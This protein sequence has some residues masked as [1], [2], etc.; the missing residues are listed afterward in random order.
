ME[1]DKSWIEWVAHN[2]AAGVQ[3]K[4]LI[5]AMLKCGAEK[6]SARILVEWVTS[7]PLI[8]AVQTMHKKHEKLASIMR[9]LN[10]VQQQA[11][12]I[13]KVDTPDEDAFYQK[14]WCQNQPAVFK[15]MV[16]DWQAMTK[17]TMPFL[18][19]NFGDCLIEIQENRE[20]DP[21]YEINSIN[22]KKKVTVREFIH[23]VGEGPSNDFYMTANN[24]IF[25][26][27]EMG[28]LLHDIGSV[29]P[30]I[31]PPKERDKS[32]F[33][34]VGPAGT[35][36]PLHHDENI[37]FHTQIK[38]R[39][40][41]KLISPMDTPN[42]YNHKAVFSEVDLFNID[43]NK[44]P[45]MRGVQIAELVV[46]PGETLFLPLGWWHGVEALEPSISVSSTAFK[47]PNH[48]KFNN[49]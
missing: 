44:F 17:W 48:W 29:P 25:E 26:T 47:Y 12:N 45:L 19:D 39:K 37:I 5:A 24:H 7:N 27:K 20:K 43:Y 2:A 14:Y 32:W 38:G 13:Q 15:G 8:T 31:A 46:E 1:L 34:W 49:P 6:D 36:T 42:L 22:H 30:Y 41:W 33:L 16:D 23:R 10:A 40:K 4:D 11:A 9:S 3:P 18:L 21:N 35:V 28:A